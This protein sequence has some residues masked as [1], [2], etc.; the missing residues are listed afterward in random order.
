MSKKA[1]SLQQKE[2]PIGV[3]TKERL[4]QY[5]YLI[6]EI[7]AQKERLAQIEASLLHPKPSIGDGMPHSNYA[8]DRMAIAIANKIELE[9]LII[10]NIKKAQQEAAAIERAIQTLNNPIDRE[11]MRLKYLDGLTWE[12]VAEKLCRSRQW[13]TVLH[14]RI[15]Q[16]LKNT[17]L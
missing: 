6:K 13:V 4:R 3:M 16:K 15:L 14:G 2:E 1:R 11:L 10:K 8:V 9:E 7:E 5:V 17:C 12:E